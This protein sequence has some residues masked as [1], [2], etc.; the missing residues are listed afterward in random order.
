MTIWTKTNTTPNK[1]KP[2]KIT[3]VLSAKFFKLK[4]ITSL[5]FFIFFLFLS[6]LAESAKNFKVLIFLYIFLFIQALLIIFFPKKPAHTN[7]NQDKFYETTT[8]VMDLSSTKTYSI[9]FSQESIQEELKKYQENF[10]TKTAPDS[11]TNVARDYLIN[12]ALLNLATSQE[13]EYQR[14]IKQ[15]KELDP[16]WEGWRQWAGLK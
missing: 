7:Q 14:L 16:N 6:L 1:T 4:L 9:N 11:P 5:L 13:S 10:F 8:Q 3:G 2:N 15:A 12:T